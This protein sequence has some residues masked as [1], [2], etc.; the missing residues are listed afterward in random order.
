MITPW[1]SRWIGKL[2][3]LQGIEI[4]SIFEIEL[5]AIP[6][7]NEPHRKSTT[8]KF[9]V[10]YGELKLGNGKESIN[11]IAKEWVG[12]SGV[13]KRDNEPEAICDSRKYENFLKFAKSKLVT[14]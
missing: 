2:S 14:Q 8:A 5:K 12:T 13:L 9:K 7:G 3:V 6:Y 1:E 10:K 4:I 11:N